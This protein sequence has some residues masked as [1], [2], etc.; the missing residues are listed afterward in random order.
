MLEISKNKAIHNKQIDCR[1]NGGK[2]SFL[3]TWQERFSEH[4]NT[5]TLILT[6]Y[7]GRE[8]VTRLDAVGQAE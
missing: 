4:N 5:Q 1:E 3:L 2:H 7:F 6:I 8:F